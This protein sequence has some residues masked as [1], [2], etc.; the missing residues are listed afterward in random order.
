M[1]VLIQELIRL[2]D[3]LMV[4]ELYILIALGLSIFQKELEILE[5]IGILQRI[6]LE[7]KHITP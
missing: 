3:M 7:Y 5:V 1:G 4:N 2:L 6:Y